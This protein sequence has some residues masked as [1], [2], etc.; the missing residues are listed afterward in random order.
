MS[1]AERTVLGA[2]LVEPA[3]LDT[4]ADILRA[5]H[6]GEPVHRRIFAAML[7]LR[8]QAIRPDIVTLRQA[9]EGEYPVVYL[10]GLLDG[11]PRVTDTSAWA[12]QVL[13]DARRR[14]LSAL[15]EKGHAWSQDESADTDAVVDRVM[16]GLSRIHEA[17]AERSYVITM[18][19]AIKDAEARLDRF[20]SAKDGITGIPTGL[21]TLDEVLGG[22]QG[23]ALYTLGARPARGKS[24]LAKQMAVNAGIAGFKV[25]FFSL[26]MLPAQV[27]QRMILGEAGLDRWEL[28]YKPDQSWPLLRDA[29]ARLKT[30]P[31]EF[32]RHESPTLAHIRTHVKRAKREGGCDLVI[33]DYFQRCEIGK[34]ER[35]EGLTKIAMG[36]KSMAQAFDVAVMLPAQLRRD[37]Q[38]RRPSLADIKECGALEHESDVVLF[39]HPAEVM[40]NGRRLDADKAMEKEFPEV[41]LIVAKHREGSTRTIHTSFMRRHVSFVEMPK[42]QEW[43]A[44]A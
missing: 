10:G 5:E 34:E 33:V 35:L 22:L 18:P 3:A 7:E 23:G 29:V 26:E 41:D 14:A 9:W 31:I 19:E 13:Q 20:V 28:K 11:L 42:A 2:A 32:D 27:A 44:E 24:A 37:A 36:L 17:G 43:R 39:L 21:P 1:E 8:E 15:M 30:L 25:L 6:F 4:A 38:E 12:R 16:Q 40:E